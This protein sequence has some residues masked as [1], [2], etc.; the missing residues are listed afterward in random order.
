MICNCNVAATIAPEMMLIGSHLRIAALPLPIE[1]I[2][3]ANVF[4]MVGMGPLY[5]RLA[6]GRTGD[7]EREPHN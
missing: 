3:L 6:Q 5:A 1:M 4:A 2:E 7:S